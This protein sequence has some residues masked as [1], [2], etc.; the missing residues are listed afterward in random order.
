MDSATT[1]EVRAHGQPR[2]ALDEDVPAGEQADQQRLP[3]ILL[4]DHLG[5]ERVRD[6]ADDAL[7]L[8]DVASVGL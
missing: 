4:A 6:G 2:N 1:R 3:Q 5:G 8:G 7:G